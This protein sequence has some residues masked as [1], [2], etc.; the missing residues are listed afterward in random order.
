MQLTILLIC[1]LKIILR[2]RTIEMDQ[3][4]LKDTLQLTVALETPLI[5]WSEVR[6]ALSN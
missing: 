3:I 4:N 1:L 6:N 2:A 5:S